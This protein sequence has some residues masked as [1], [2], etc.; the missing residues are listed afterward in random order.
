MRRIAAM[1]YLSKPPP[2][3]P[4][5]TEGPHPFFQFVDNEY[6]CRTEPRKGHVNLDSH[7]LISPIFARNSTTRA[8]GC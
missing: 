1:C 4:P 5:P 6:P 8:N 2:P 3:P 7:F